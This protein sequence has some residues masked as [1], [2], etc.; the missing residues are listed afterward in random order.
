[1]AV[2]NESR[3]N[4][5][6]LAW[7][8]LSIPIILF[9]DA[10]HFYPSSWYSSPSAPLHIFHLARQDYIAQ[11]NDPIIQWSPST[12]VPGSHDSWI[13]L[14]LYLEFGFT[15]P[16]VLYGFFLLAV[17]RKG[18]TG[19]DELL[20][21]VY[22]LE[23]ALTTLV[24]IYDVGYWDPAVYSE[25]AKRTMVLQFFGPWFLV[26]SIMAVDMARRILGRIKV[27]DEAMEER[28]RRK[29]Q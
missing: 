8:A 7:F 29:G 22:A 4:Y 17:K 11:Y 27:A 5:V 2:Y 20:F 12:S 16:A 18:T 23:T 3:L 10:L 13:G 9:I 28:Q 24:C 19:R 14:F 1:M 21:L 15:L 26:P 6:W 25:E